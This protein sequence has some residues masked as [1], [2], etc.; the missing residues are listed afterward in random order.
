MSPSFDES[1]F[2]EAKIFYINT[3]DKTQVDRV[4]NAAAGADEAMLWHQRP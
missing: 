4:H 2:L 3:P 1:F